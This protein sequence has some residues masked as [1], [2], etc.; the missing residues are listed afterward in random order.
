MPLE[1]FPIATSPVSSDMAS[2]LQTANDAAARTALGLGTLATQNGTFSGT[3]SGTNTGDQTTVSG[4]AGT[5]TALATGRTI[6][7]TGDVTATTGSFDGTA[8]ATA[9]ATI[10]NDAVTYAKMQNVSAAS[11][12]I[13]R[14]SDGGAGNPEEITLGTGLTMTGTTLS[15]PGG[16]TGDVVGPASA[17]NNNVAVFDGTTGKLLKDSG[18]SVLTGVTSSSGAGDAGK[19][20]ILD[21][22][23]LLDNSF[24]NLANAT[25]DGTNLIGYRGAPQLLKTADYTFVL[26][27]AGFSLFHP[28]SDNNAR[29][30]T[31]P[32]NA[33]VAFPIGTILEFINMAAASCTIPITS[34]TL[35]LLPAGTTGTRT[36]AQYGR[37]SAEKVSSTSWI[38][39]GNS[40]LS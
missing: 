21:G 6:S 29:A 20:P 12:L 33:S 24:L 32:A 30:F 27:D 36:L 39:S 22:T 13:G 3:S 5:A 26:G 37:A 10:A 35:T 1:S 38:I 15:A 34:D 31:I 16:G 25:V 9:A 17:V 4:N 8:N 2:F 23:G 14:G 40:A 18:A 7:L 11:R 28:S 19:V